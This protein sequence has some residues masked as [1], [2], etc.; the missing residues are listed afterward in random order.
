MPK[1]NYKYLDQRALANQYKIS[2][3]SVSKA[4]YR[5]DLFWAKKE[6]GKK[7]GIN[8]EDPRNIPYLTQLT[9]SNS[10]NRIDVKAAKDAKRRLK[11]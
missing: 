7:D 5:G 10:G 11:G 1:I 9:N 3:Q 2:Q 8:P 6:N 4:L